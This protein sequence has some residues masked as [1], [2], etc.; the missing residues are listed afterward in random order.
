MQ[1]AHPQLFDDSPGFAMPNFPQNDFK[2]YAETARRGIKGEAFFESLIVDFA[3][4][5]RIARQ[6]DL[7]VDFLCEW[8]HGDRPTG[9]LFSAQ[10]KSTTSQSVSCHRIGTSRLNCLEEFE[11]RG[12][13]GI[14]DRTLSYWRGLGLPAYLFYVIE[15]ES[16]GSR[17]QTCYHKRYTP[18][19]DG[20]GDASD[21]TGS[22]RFYKVSQGSQFHAFANNDRM[23][24]GFA[25]DLIIDY[26]RLAYS[27]GY[28]V[29]LIPS[30]LGFW[31]F[32]H[33][34]APEATK[35]FDEL[36]GWHRDKIKAA[37]DWATSVL[38][39]LPPE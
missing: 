35:Y 9:I 28:L 19:L 24:W 34:S 14:D 27:K 11:L 7:G 30:E 2:K 23:L 17:T 25:R 21:R 15:S 12:A 13:D 6:N 10:I 38:S 26:A 33:R 20:K 5:H 31:P 39:L 18:V 22:H 16:D 3:I 36:V 4:P 8:T 1:F 29:P 37:R 32:P